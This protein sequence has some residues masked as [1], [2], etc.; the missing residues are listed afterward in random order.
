MVFLR[1]RKK[2]VSGSSATNDKHLSSRSVIIDCKQASRRYQSTLGWKLRAKSIFLCLSRSIH[3]VLARLNSIFRLFSSPFL[4]H[5]H[6]IF[7]ISARKSR[8]AFHIELHNP[9][10]SFQHYSLLFW[11]LLLFV[12]IACNSIRVIFSLCIMFETGGQNDEAKSTRHNHSA[13]AKPKTTDRLLN[14]LD[15]PL[16]TFRLQWQ[17]PDGCMTHHFTIDFF[18]VCVL[19]FHIL[20][21]V[22]LCVSSFCVLVGFFYFSFELKLLLTQ[23]SNVSY[24]V[25]HSKHR[26]MHIKKIDQK[27][28]KFDH[29]FGISKQRTNNILSYS[30]VSMEIH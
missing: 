28:R 5:S 9:V 18:F 4:L 11:L 14:V 1:E 27:K 17:Q 20:V 19:P 24:F 7:S 6:M 13:F 29:C 15:G 10:L 2:R 23:L 3:R 12:L 30:F 25:Q 26:K 8:T 16:C 22:S 21:S